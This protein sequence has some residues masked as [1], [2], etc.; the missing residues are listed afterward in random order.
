MEKKTIGIL[1]G[2]AAGIGPEQVVKILSK[3]Y[4]QERCNA[5]LLG[6]ERVFCQA[7]ELVG[8]KIPYRRITSAEEI[9]F[10]D[11]ELC[12]YDMQDIDPAEIKMGQVDARCG[13][14]CIRQI[15]LAIQLWKDGVIGG[16]IFAAM[17]KAAEKAAIGEQYASEFTYFA[18]QLGYT[19]YAS[20]VNHMDHICTIRIVSHVPMKKLCETLTQ[21][22][23]EAAIRLLYSTIRKLGNPQPRV[24]VAALNPH[25]GDAGTCGRE[26]ID[27]LQPAIQAMNQAGYPTTGPY[28]AD[29]I[30]DRAFRKNEF[31]GIVTMYHD[32]GQ[33]ALKLKGFER[34]V[35]IL[36][37][38]PMPVVT[39]AHGTAFDIAGKGVAS[40]EAFEHTVD[41]MLALLQNW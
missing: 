18:E 8:V 4:V 9:S 24:G 20:E 33:I 14:S 15:D 13:M 39:P 34:G 3:R 28:P 25:G 12:L 1:L 22:K 29:T 10:A 23:V 27:I 36:A 17:N 30:F 5:I 7:M 38:L 16:A 21:D 31:D 40:I 19:G 41:D 11:T 26:E 32:Q 35:S 6:D 37:G 2:D